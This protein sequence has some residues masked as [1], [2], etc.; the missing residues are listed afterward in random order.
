[1][2]EQGI[3]GEMINKVFASTVETSQMIFSGYRNHFPGYSKLI[4]HMLIKPPGREKN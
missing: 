1:M 2:L 4:H 3:A